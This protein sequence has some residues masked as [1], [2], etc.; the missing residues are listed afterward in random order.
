LSVIGFFHSAFQVI[1][2]PHFT[3]SLHTSHHLT[4]S[5][6]FITSLHHLTSSP[7]FITSLHHLTSPHFTSLHLTSPP[8][9]T[10]SSHHIHIA[11]SLQ[12]ICPSIIRDTNESLSNRSNRIYRICSSMYFTTPWSYCF[13]FSSK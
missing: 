7:H 1:P 5:P 4:S 11:S 6:H 3:T 12:L 10:T 2:L 9:F 8:H 13:W